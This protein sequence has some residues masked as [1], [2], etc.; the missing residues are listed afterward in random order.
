MIDKVPPQVLD[1]ERAVLGAIL[2]ERPA[3]HNVTFLSPEMF[4]KP[5][6][7]IIYRALIKL[8]SSGEPIDILS[9]TNELLS[10]GELTQAGGAVYISELSNLVSSSA[11][12]EN[13]ARKIVE[14]YILREVIRIC[15]EL[16]G[17][18][19]EDCIDVFDLL[20]KATKMFYDLSN[21]INSGT[22]K[23]AQ[24][25]KKQIEKDIIEI[26][27]GIKKP[28]IIPTCVEN[29]KLQ[30][31]TVTVIGAKPG[32]GKT[33]FITSSATVH[34]RDGYSVGI[35]SI[36][37]TD[38]KLTARI[39]QQQLGIS[40][41]RLVHGDIDD[42]QYEKLV[43][44]VVPQN[45]FI[46]ATARVTASNIRNQLVSFIIKYKCKVLYIDYFQK[47]I[48]TDRKS[49]TDAQYELLET[50]CQVAKEYDVAVC[51]LSQLTRGGDDDTD[52]MEK[53]RGG[54]IEQG[55]SEVYIF[56]DKYKKQNNDM[57]WN[58]IPVDRRGELKYECVKNRD[59]NYMGGVIY[60]DKPHQKMMDWDKRPEQ[61]EPMINQRKDL[62]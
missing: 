14:K 22:I 2:I 12:I 19:Y 34:S 8:N 32:T 33:A 48:I 43:E 28:G 1:F 36:E 21:C 18:G 50:I 41:K 5:A 37:M 6:H 4:Y 52:W 44:T 10:T 62:F 23:S 27:A 40:A 58:D 61:A 29:I 45:I 35:K 57:H 9:V 24:D 59:D 25:I 53:L 31:G 42:D 11:N 39:I 55:A 49:T 38:T 26:K 15:H 30:T 3:F 13:H 51:V 20:D 46:D 60:F 56:I 7:E 16:E 54:G 17:E 47:I